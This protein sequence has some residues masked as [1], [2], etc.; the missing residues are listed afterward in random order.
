VALCSLWVLLYAAFFTVWSPGYFVFWAPALAPLAVLLGLAIGSLPRRC[1]KPAQ[2]ILLAWLAL[3]ATVTWVCG[4]RPGLSPSASRPEQIARDIRAH[5]APKDLVVVVGAGDDAQ[6]EVD[7]PYYSQRNL[8]SLHSTLTTAKENI[9]VALAAAKG[10]IAHT[11]RLGH[12]VYA[13]DE[14]LHGGR[15]LA[16][17]YARHPAFTPAELH[18][19]IGVY[20]WRPAWVDGLVRIWRLDIPQPSR[21]IIARAPFSVRQVQRNSRTSR[22]RRRLEAWRPSRERV[23]WPAWYRAPDLAKAG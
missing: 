13:L 2:K 20:P 19:L 23:P 8:L 1:G 15:A 22:V 11:L 16:A 12:T 9:P 7:I 14:V 3:C 17:L 5:T 6:C 4:I 21:S 18:G 10:Q